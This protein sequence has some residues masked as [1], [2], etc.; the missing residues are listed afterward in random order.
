MNDL[1]ETTHGGTAAPT[2]HRQPAA[3]TSQT[4]GRRNPTIATFSI[5]ARDPDSGDMGVAVASKFLAVGAYVP[6]AKADLGAVASQASGNTTYGGRAMRLLQEGA[7]PAAVAAEFERT[8]PDFQA[9]QFGIVSAAGVGFTF[10]G[11]KCHDWAGGVAGENFAAQ[12]NILTG[13][14]VVE[15]MVD[16]FHRGDLPFPERLVACL[17]AAEAAGGDSRGRQSAALLVVGAGKG[18]LGLTDRWIDLR[19]DDSQQPVEELRRLL[20]VHRSF[21][22]PDA[23]VPPDVDE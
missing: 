21:F 4:D 11:S 8:D 7:S 15:A 13:P 10:T 17:E 1:G 14:D 22:A 19:C 23:A 18:Y 12:G 5:A 20:E 3:S 9:R 2:D 16:A 6:T